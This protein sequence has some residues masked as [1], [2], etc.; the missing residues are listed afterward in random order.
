MKKYV[1]T[2]VRIE[3]NEL[4]KIKG[5][6]SSVELSLFFPPGQ[7]PVEFTRNE[8][9]SLIRQGSFFDKRINDKNIPIRL[10]L[11]KNTVNL[12]DSQFK[13]ITKY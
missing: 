8:M 9:I 7:F 6:M 5:Y 12:D 10:N 13:D 2:A 11:V 3:N 1:I 4:I